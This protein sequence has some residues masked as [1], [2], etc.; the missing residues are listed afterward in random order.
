[1][2]TTTTRVLHWKVNITGAVVAVAKA[3]TTTTTVSF[4]LFLPRNH[5]FKVEKLSHTVCLSQRAMRSK[6]REREREDKINE[7]ISYDCY[8]GRCCFGC[9]G[10]FKK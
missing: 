3:A 7:I 6:E 4:G 1:M 8:C 2:T 10:G 9:G 5:F